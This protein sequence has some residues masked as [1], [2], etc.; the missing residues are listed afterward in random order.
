MDPFQVLPFTPDNLFTSLV[1][2]F[3]SSAEVAVH[4]RA[5]YLCRYLGYLQ[6]RT[7]VVEN[8]Y[9]DGDYLDDYASYYVKCFRHYY[10]RCKR[11][12]FFDR[13]FDKTEFLQL[14]RGELLSWYAPDL[15]GSYLG[16]VVARPLPEAIIG[17]TLL[18]TY[19]TDDGRRNYPCTR[20]YH[21]NLFGLDLHVTSLPFQ[22]QDTVLAACATVSLWSAFHK[23]AELF[24]TPTPTPV[25][26]TRV[27][28]QVIQPARPLPS[29]GLTIQQICNSIRHIGLDPEVVEM[30][31]STPIVSLIYGHLFMGLPVLLVVGVPGVG[32]HA[33]TLT[34]Y[35]LRKQPVR[36]TEVAPGQL[37]IPLPGLRIDEFYGHDDTIG[38]FT[39]LVI[40]HP[41][42]PQNPFTGKPDLP[43]FFEESV[44]DPRSGLTTGRQMFP[45]MIVVPVYHKIRVTFIDVLEWLTR[46]HRYVVQYLG[47]PGAEWNLHLITTNNYKSLIKNLGLTKQ[48][49]ES[50]LFEHHPRFIWRAT[51]RFNGTL[52]L[53]L[54]ADATDMA[55]SFPLYRAVWCDPNVRNGTITL[56]N[57]P[58]TQATLRQ[59]LTPRFCD[60]LINAP[61]P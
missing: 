43:V 53:E 20:N 41:P 37:I 57:A 60:L 50:L 26:I 2:S 12:H 4:S 18:K 61:A 49:T 19:P 51:L 58:A 22:E 14:V 30:R 9:T 24:G 15:T 42:P 46:F 36:A 5:Q 59:D 23:T 7:I 25:D 35:S 17:R 10:R 47:A 13:A 40:R 6:A 44:T 11:L 54:L 56:L 32:L 21:A 1:N 8:D 48:Q 29:H 3:M 27:A 33:I 31:N 38:P 55:R 52:A 34:G 39:R 45:L 16:F 28:N